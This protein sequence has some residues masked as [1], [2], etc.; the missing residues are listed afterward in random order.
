MRLSAYSLSGEMDCWAV[1]AVRCAT[2]SSGQAL[3]GEA[4]TSGF[5]ASTVKPTRITAPSL[6]RVLNAIAAGSRCSAVRQ[7]E[8]EWVI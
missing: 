3:G 8:L 4:V 5:P 7:Y 6:G 1:L 2:R